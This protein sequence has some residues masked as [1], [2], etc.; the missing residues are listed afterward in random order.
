MSK[1][2]LGVQAPAKECTDGKCPFHG[3][4]NVKKE[5]FKGIVVKK[6]SNNSATIEW[7]RPYYVPKYERYELRRSRMRVHNTP[8]VNA[9]VGQEVLAARTRPLSKT[10][11]HVVLTTLGEKKTAPPKLTVEKITKEKKVELNESAKQ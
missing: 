11:N 8:C 6:D 3:Q 5:L 10:K 4:L 1:K 9:E 7:F 2:I